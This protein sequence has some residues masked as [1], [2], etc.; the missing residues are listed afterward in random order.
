MFAHVYSAVLPIFITSASPAFWA[1]ICV[2]NKQVQDKESKLRVG[3]TFGSG[4]SIIQQRPEEGWPL[5]I[6]SR[7][8]QG[9]H[10]K[11]R[12]Y[13]VD[14]QVRYWFIPLPS[15][16]TCIHVLMSNNVI[17]E[18]SVF[19]YCPNL[20]ILQLVACDPAPS[21]HRAQKSPFTR[22]LWEV[23]FILPFI[24]NEALSGRFYEEIC[25]AVFLCSGAFWSHQI[26]Y[27]SVL[28][29]AL[30]FCLCMVVSCIWWG[31]RADNVKSPTFVIW[32][33]NMTGCRRVFKTME[34]W[35]SEV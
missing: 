13:C 19:H 14:L 29:P 16:Y 8:K 33:S 27:K 6:L 2:H 1:V 12:L 30:H 35:K 28:P 31:V 18:V 10:A 21:S 32:N 24:L 4:L 34:M 5:V 11:P 22:L 7:I 23:P 26:F 15:L 25:V 17:K 3:L 20:S 9:L